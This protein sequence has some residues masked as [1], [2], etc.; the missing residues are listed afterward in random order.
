M[1]EGQSLE[2]QYEIQL[3]AEKLY[4]SL[5]LVGS[6]AKEEGLKVYLDDLADICRWI[7]VNDQ[8][9]QPFSHTYK[10]LWGFKHKR[11]Y[12]NFANEAQLVWV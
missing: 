3:I 12:V 7:L 5:G 1:Q 4:C 11:S 6:N 8:M 9:Q 10:V 2:T